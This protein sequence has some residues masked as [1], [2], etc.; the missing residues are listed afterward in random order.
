MLYI[1]LKINNV[2]IIYELN[3]LFNNGIIVIKV[4]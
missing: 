4:Q 3:N 1:Y 2:I